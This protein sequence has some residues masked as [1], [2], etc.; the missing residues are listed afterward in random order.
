M[1]S[2]ILG[3][4]ALMRVT[5]VGGELTIDISRLRAE[6]I[7]DIPEAVFGEL[8]RQYRALAKDVSSY[9]DALKVGGIT[10]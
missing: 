9:E 2:E 6:H 3:K 5:F 8:E 1:T 7:K 10:L 4:G